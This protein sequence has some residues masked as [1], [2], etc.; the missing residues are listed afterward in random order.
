MERDVQPMWIDPYD[1]PPWNLK[2]FNRMPCCLEPVLS[3]S[4]VQ[5]KNTADQ[6]EVYVL[7]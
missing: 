7:E 5:K 6:E 4:I 2:T 3:C 1:W